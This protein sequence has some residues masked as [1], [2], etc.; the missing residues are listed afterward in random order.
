[1]YDPGRTITASKLKIGMWLLKTAMSFWKMQQ[2]ICLT[3]RQHTI[4]CIHQ[5]FVSCLQ[6][7]KS[8]VCMCLIHDVG[9]L[10]KHSSNIDHMINADTDNRYY[11]GIASYCCPVPAPSF[12]T[13]ES[14]LQQMCSDAA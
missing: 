5:P 4:C 6:Y 12:H 10:Q 3:M 7:V 11:N 9:M 8:A 14:V 2:G 1:M 13:L